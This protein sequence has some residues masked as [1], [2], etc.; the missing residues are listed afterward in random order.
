[1]VLAYAIISTHIASKVPFFSVSNMLT[2]QCLLFVARVR[3]AI[4]STLIKNRESK[5]KW[6]VCV[7]LMALCHSNMLAACRNPSKLRQLGNGPGE[8]HGPTVSMEAKKMVRI[9]NRCTV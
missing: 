8:L 9:R 6:L 1:M 2:A 3:A 5:M 7:Y 4:M